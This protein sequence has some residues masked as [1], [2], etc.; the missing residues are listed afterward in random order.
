M[1]HCKHTGLQGVLPD[2]IHA[3]HRLEPLRQCVAQQEVFQWHY[4]PSGC[5][6]VSFVTSA[7]FM[8]ITPCSGPALGFSPRD[9]PE[10]CCT[11][12]LQFL[13]PRDVSGADLMFCSTRGWYTHTHTRVHVIT[14]CSRLDIWWSISSCVLD[15]E[16]QKMAHCSIIPALQ[17]QLCQSLWVPTVSLP[18]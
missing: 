16:E 17:R 3:H 18:S 13:Q 10:Q 12:D 1:V 7:S 15:A 8:A 6:W 2:E 9:L 14:L 5:V 4:D 11:H